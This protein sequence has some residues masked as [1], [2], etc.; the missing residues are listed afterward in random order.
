MAVF[1]VAQSL[2][3]DL[4][5]NFWVTIYKPCEIYKRIYD[6]YREA[7]FRAKIFTNGVNMG[8]LDPKMLLTKCVYKSD[9]FNI[10]CIKRIWN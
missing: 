10:R 5:S 7:Y 4:L 3:R 1:Q 9:I 6:M 2:N 8:L